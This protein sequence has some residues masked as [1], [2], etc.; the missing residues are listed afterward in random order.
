MLNPSKV[1]DMFNSR[2]LNNN[3]S[4]IHEQTLSLVYQNNLNFSGLLDLDNYL[5]VH[6]KN[7]Q[8]LVTKI[9][10]VKNEIAREIM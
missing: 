8:V 5:T 1:K 7:L 4:R 9:Y 3:I 6:R 2:N 10:N